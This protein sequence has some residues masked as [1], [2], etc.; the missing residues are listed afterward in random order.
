MYQS[1]SFASENSRNRLSNTKRTELIFNA[2]VLFHAQ[3]SYIEP[4]KTE[5]LI[6]CLE[7]IEVEVNQLYPTC[8]LR[9]S[10]D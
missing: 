5:I 9:G 7:H 8:H 1:K 2:Y 10:H 6:K 3:K 4:F